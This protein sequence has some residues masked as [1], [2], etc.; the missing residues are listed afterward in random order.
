MEDCTES[1]Q[2]WNETRCEESRNQVGPT[3]PAAVGPC[4]PSEPVRYSCGF[5][6]AS[7]H[8]VISGCVETRVECT[9]SH[10]FGKYGGK[11]EYERLLYT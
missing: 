10:G 1:H 3:V 9:V 5:A 4:A 7:E 2:I 6:V 11:A 8:A